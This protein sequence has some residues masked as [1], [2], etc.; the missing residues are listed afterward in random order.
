MNV[1]RTPRTREPHWG[2]LFGAQARAGHFLGRKEPPPPRGTGR[3][4]PPPFSFL[5]RPGDVGI[6]TDGRKFSLSRAQAGK[7]KRP[8]CWWKSELSSPPGHFWP[9]RFLT[10]CSGHGQSILGPFS[11]EGRRRTLK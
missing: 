5:H 4:P 7:A 10:F 9:G 3:S 2:N 11:G 8:H 1:R 6:L